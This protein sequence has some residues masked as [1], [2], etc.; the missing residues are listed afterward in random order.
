MKKALIVGVN[1]YGGNNNLSGCINDAE[2]ISTLLERDENGDKNFHIKKSLD[3]QAKGEL[4][5]QIRECFSG[6][7][8]VALFY[9]RMLEPSEEF[10]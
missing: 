6:N 7:E 5:G 4:N 2:T 10:Y 1:N 3:V 9:C 8:D